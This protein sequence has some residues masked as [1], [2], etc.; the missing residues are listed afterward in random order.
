MHFSF[1]NEVKWGASEKIFFVVVGQVVGVFCFQGGDTD[2]EIRKNKVIVIYIWEFC[3]IPVSVR[4]TNYRYFRVF[5]MEKKA[6]APASSDY[7]QINW[8]N[9]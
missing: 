9:K 2:L 7:F 8:D 5:I 6:E 3:I 4:V 1:I